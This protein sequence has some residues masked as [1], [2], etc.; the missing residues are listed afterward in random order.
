MNTF[1]RFDEEKLCARKYFFS[2]TKKGKID[3]DGK[4]S[5]GHISIEDYL[6][7]EKT[8]NKFK[9]KN[10]GDYHDHY[11]KKDVLLLADVFETFI[12]TCLKYY[13]LDPCHY[14]SSS[15][16]SW[17]A[18][19]K[20]TDVK[21]EKIDKYLFIEKGSRG[22]ISYIAKRYAKAKNKYMNDY[23][24]EKPAIFITYLDKNNLYGWTMS[25]YL[26]YREFNW[27]KNVDKFDVNLINEKSIFS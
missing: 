4:I 9:M 26:P 10:M 3:E 8:W 25:E 12:K 27:L 16:L 24:P 7:C 1:K 2:S 18:M 5:D 13:E 15:G 22:G 20:M 14:F 6:T 21:L 23:D 11:L 17:D 19:L